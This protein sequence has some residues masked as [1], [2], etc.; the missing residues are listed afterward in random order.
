MCV[1]LCVCRIDEDMNETQ[2]NECTARGD[3]PPPPTLLS[4]C[5][6]HAPALSRRQ[7]QRQMRQTTLVLSSFAFTKKKIPKK[8]TGT[9]A[10][11]L[12]PCVCVCLCVA[13]N[14]VAQMMCG[15]FLG[16]TVFCCNYLQRVQKEGKELR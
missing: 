14:P 6:C 11:N 3:V 9:D 5:L 7:N 8:K 12:R 2:M 4:S 10:A 15:I 16:Y 13:A 1:C